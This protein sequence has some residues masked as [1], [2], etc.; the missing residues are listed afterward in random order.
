VLLDDGVTLLPV[1]V[2]NTVVPAYNSVGCVVERPGS[3]AVLGDE[4]AAVQATGR[5]GR[6]TPGGWAGE[7]AE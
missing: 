1:N 3:Y 6:S 5:R 4:I 2:P 7:R